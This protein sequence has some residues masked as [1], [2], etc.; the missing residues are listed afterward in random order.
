MACLATFTCN[1]KTVRVLIDSIQANCGEH[2]VFL[3]SFYNGVEDKSQIAIDPIGGSLFIYWLDEDGNCCHGDPGVSGQPG[4]FM[5]SAFLQEAY[6]AAGNNR[7]LTSEELQA[8]QKIPFSVDNYSAS[9]MHFVQFDNTMWRRRDDG[10]A[11]QEG[12]N[13]FFST[14]G[15]VS[16]DLEFCFFPVY[17]NGEDRCTNYSGLLLPNFVSGPNQHPNICKTRALPTSISMSSDERLNYCVL[18]LPHGL[19]IN[20]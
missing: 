11:F 6:S 4:P 10:L 9:G 16:L 20:E 1:K 13:H 19:E 18:S 17:A 15:I 7:I 3:S 8:F 2:K 12:G 5:V 14:P